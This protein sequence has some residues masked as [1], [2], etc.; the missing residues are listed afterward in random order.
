MQQVDALFPSD[1]AD[2]RRRFINLATEAGCR[3]TSYA[4][5][6]LRGPAGEELACD[7]ARFG[8]VAPRSVLLISSGTHGVEGF[9]GSGIQ[10]A[11]LDDGVLRSFAGDTAVVLVHAVNPY[12][13]AH[14]RRTNEDNVDLNRNF[15]DHRRSVPNPAYD[16]IHDWLIPADWDGP[17]RAEADAEIQRYI[18]T[19]GLRAFQAALTG[20]Q[21]MHPD[22]LFYGGLRAAWSNATWRQVLRD[23]CT[24]A[25]PI[26]AI[27]LHTG[28]GPSGVG[29]AIC[30]GAEDEHLR[31][32][33][34]FG[35]DVVWTGSGGSVSAQVGGSLVH[36]AHE[37]LGPERLTMIALEYGTHPI[38]TTLEALRAEAWLTARGDV[39]SPQGQRIKQALREAFYVDESA[40]KRAVVDRLLELVERLKARKP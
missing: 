3:L 39:R 30:V 4:H 31:A 24:Q 40:W 23:H 2:G 33:A 10:A 7:V 19:R 12:G 11:L 8:P 1:Y 29:E 18:D 9:C 25:I 13:F 26:V 14:L 6:A 17:A 21:Y 16:E 35:D 38:S 15:V 5:P 34:L 37:E 27:D 20:G 28:L 22:G 32:K 36:G